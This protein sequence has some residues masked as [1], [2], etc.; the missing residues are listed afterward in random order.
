LRV[1]SWKYPRAFLRAAVKILRA[2]HA[3]RLTRGDKG[4]DQFV[5]AADA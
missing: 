1:V 4:F 2:R 5:A 3:I